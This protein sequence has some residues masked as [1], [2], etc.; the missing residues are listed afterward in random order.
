[1]GQVR[2]KT[3]QVKSFSSRHDHF[4]YSQIAVKQDVQQEEEALVT[5]GYWQVDGLRREPTK[6]HKDRRQH[7]H[8]MQRSETTPIPKDQLLDEGEI[9]IQYQE[10]KKKVLQKD[11]CRAER[12]RFSDK[13]EEFWKGKTVY[14]I[15]K[16]HEIPEDV[17]RSD[18][19]P[20]SQTF[21]RRHRH[22]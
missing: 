13:M 10:S 8:E 16:D 2:F 9:H 4:T 3:P 17:V 22:R 6:H 21:Q 18:I 7:L 19:G 5:G 11:T 14:K 15:K 20:S 1:M 12:K